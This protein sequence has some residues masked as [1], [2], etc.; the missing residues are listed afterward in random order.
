MATETETT[1]KLSKLLLLVFV[2]LFA[3]AVESAAQTPNSVNSS[4]TL[5][6]DSGTRGTVASIPPSAPGVTPVIIPSSHSTSDPRICNWANVGQPLSGEGC[7]NIV[8]ANVQIQDFRFG[9]YQTGVN[10]LGSQPGTNF[11]AWHRWD[12]VYT[13]SNGVKGLH[14]TNLNLNGLY[15]GGG[16]N[17][18]QNGYVNL[19]WQAVQE[20]FANSYTP[21]NTF[22][23]VAWGN[24]YS[25]GDILGLYALLRCYGGFAA[26]A[27]EGCEAIDVQ[28]TEGTQEFTGTIA[29]STSTTV[30]ITVT[31]GNGTQGAGRYLVDQTQAI[32]GNATSIAQPGG[33]TFFQVT[34]SGASFPVSSVNTTLGTAVTAPGSA[35]VTPGSLTEISAGNIL[36]IAGTKTGFEQITVASVNSGAGT[37]TATYRYPH[38]NTDAVV[39]GGLC[40]YYF[41]FA[42]DD[43]T[44]SLWAE[45]SSS[46]P[47]HWQIPVVRSLS[48]TTFEVWLVNPDLGPVTYQGQWTLSTPGYRLWPGAE[49]T[50]VMTPGGQTL[51]STLTV[52]P[53]SVVWSNSD[54]VSQPHY[55]SIQANH[56]LFARTSYHPDQYGPPGELQFIFRG[57]K[58][59]AGIS[60]M[61]FENDT[62][63]SFYNQQAWPRLIQTD[64][65]WG[66]YFRASIPPHDQFIDFNQ[67][68]TAWNL[69]KQEATAGRGY[70]TVD[71]VNH[72][73]HIGPQFNPQFINLDWVNG[74]VNAT[75]I[76]VGGVNAA[77]LIASGTATLGTGPISATRCATVVA[78]SAPGALSTD[79][80]S[81]AF[82]AAPGSGY[83]S[84]LNVLGYVTANNVNFLVCNPT[85]GSLTP[86]AAM[87]NWRVIR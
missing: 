45:I 58:T 18:F 27:G 5:V 71:P 32:T 56:G 39:K 54:T 3:G 11:A 35:T 13:T 25:T 84:G 77:K 76:Q 68:T 55:F 34:D 6:G 57:Q 22:P 47:L 46:N 10:V 36:C 14:Q 2:L 87:L 41:N 51:S 64:G 53:H 50:S 9:D 75:A 66:T 33:T 49:V 67:T 29:S 30:T 24:K 81:W 19:P 7:F 59:N 15:L 70:F 78:T 83:T 73:F 38:L 20:N 86:A 85:A 80:I 69:V 17:I 60:A 52:E 8:S 79:T 63:T 23:F 28:A 21:G 82:N 72:W 26:G 61:W 12:S 37:F 65:N 48:G 62:P 31:Q 1:M 42:A 74:I 43:A 16:T 4:G 40:G 44:H